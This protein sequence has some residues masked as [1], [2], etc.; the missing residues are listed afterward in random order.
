M[1]QNIKQLVGKNIKQ[2]RHDL[3]WTQQMLAEKVNCDRSV[4]ARVESGDRASFDVENL[5][6]YAEVFGCKLI[7]LLPED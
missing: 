2:R 5:S 3:N 4:I 6:R 7:E 1:Y